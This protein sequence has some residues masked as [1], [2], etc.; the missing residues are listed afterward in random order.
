MEGQYNAG[1]AWSCGPYLDQTWEE[2]VRDLLGDLGALLKSHDGIFG[3]VPGRC[4]PTKPN[5]T[6][7]KDDWGVSTE[8]ED[9]RTVYLHVLNRPDGGIL[10]LAFPAN[11]RRF[12]EAYCGE[13]KLDLRETANGYEIALPQTDDGIDTVIRLC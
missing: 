7:S 12:A 8:S 13:I 4:Y 2:G 1:I 9:G 5:S 10:K 6:L 3:T 11:G